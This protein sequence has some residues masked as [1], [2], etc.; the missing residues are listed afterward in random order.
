MKDIYSNVRFADGTKAPA[1]RFYTS[2]GKRAFDLLLAAIILPVILPILSVLWVCVR[3]DGGPGFFG[4]E[5]V[6]QNGR[7]F[8]CWKLRTMCLNAEAQLHRLCAAD[9]KLAQEW[10]ENQKLENDPRIT[11]VG[12]FL[13]ASSLD[14]LPQIWNVIRGDMS[15][16]GPRPFTSDQEHL[17]LAAGGRAYFKLRPGIS[18]LWQVEGRN[19]TTFVDR[20][21][22]DNRYYDQASLLCDLVILLKTAGVVISRT[23]K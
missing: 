12:R 1:Y 18:G 11:R 8:T 9:P 16:I 4:Q 5:R 10:Y 22:F 15:F 21:K 13:R 20:I 17:Y 23:G 6:G 14:E 7:R 2:I 19:D 3:L